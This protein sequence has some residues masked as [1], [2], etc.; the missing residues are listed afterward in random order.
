MAPDLAGA[1]ATL[2][3]YVLVGQSVPLP[4]L[5]SGV[6]SGRRKGDH[7]PIFHMEQ[8]KTGLALCHHQP[9]QLWNLTWLD[10]LLVSCPLIRCWLFHLGRRWP[11]PVAPAGGPPEAVGAP[12][13]LPDSTLSLA[14]SSSTPTESVLVGQSLPRPE[15]PSS[16]PTLAPDT[17]LPPAVVM[18]IDQMLAG[19]P[20]QALPQLGHSPGAPAGGPPEAERAPTY[21][22][23]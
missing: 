20:E 17:A 22:P 5:P 15:P 12:T 3:E 19:S 16:H 14:V 18:L 2:S 13:Y 21:L 8:P 7:P 1:S 11:S 6:D 23:T 4:G 9:I 10:P